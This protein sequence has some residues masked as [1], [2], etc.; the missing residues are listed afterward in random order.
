MA[1]RTQ[2]LSLYKNMM[3]ESYKFPDFNF[4]SYAVRRVR[5][6]FK[7]SKTL[8]DTNDISKQL[9]N[10]RMNFEVIKRQA[11]ISH[12]FDIKQ[13]LTIEKLSK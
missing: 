10:A 12:L 3:R 5:D 1:S 6:E 13:P 11:T 4:R 2:I 7:A 9:A 8:S